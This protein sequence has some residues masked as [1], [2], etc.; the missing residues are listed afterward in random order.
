LGERYAEVLA[1][2]HRLLRAAFKA[3][4]GVEVETQG[5][6]LFVAFPRAGDAVLA[7]V[8]AQRAITTRDWPKDAAL[9]V[10][11]GLHTGEAFRAHTGYVGIDVHR[12]ARICAAGHGGQTLLSDATRDLI[13]DALPQEIA[14]RDLVSIA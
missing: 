14:V 6:A 3:R 1:E 7:A 5:D 9:R 13:L 8:E 4:G 12:A 11:M 10:R 2:H